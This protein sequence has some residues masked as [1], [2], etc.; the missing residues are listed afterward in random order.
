MESDKEKD[1]AILERN[2]FDNYKT[3]IEI[4]KIEFKKYK[5]NIEISECW[6]V[7]NLENI[8]EKRPSIKIGYT[9]WLSYRILYNDKPVV[10]D[11]ENSYLGNSYGVVMISRKKLFGK[12]LEITVTQ[13]IED[14][15]KDLEEDLMFVKNMY[16]EL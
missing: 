10:Y 9:Y 12:Q 7:H 14:V 5:C 2:V 4:Y 16:H 1:I 6:T 8:Y 11:D 15:K 3:L 13:N